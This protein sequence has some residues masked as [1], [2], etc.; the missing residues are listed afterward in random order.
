[1][2]VSKKMNSDCYVFF[3]FM[4]LIS[5]G[6]KTRLTKRLNLKMLLAFTKTNT[7]LKGLSKLIEQNQ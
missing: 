1:M 5:I 6:I 7:L 4:E 3:F 2:S